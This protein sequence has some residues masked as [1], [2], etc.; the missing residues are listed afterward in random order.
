MGTKPAASIPQKIQ[1]YIND[2]KE[3]IA[4]ISRAKSSMPTGISTQQQATLKKVIAEY[5]RNIKFTTDQNIQQLAQLITPLRQPVF[6]ALGKSRRDKLNEKANTLSPS[7]ANYEKQYG[8][9]I[10]SFPSQ[11]SNWQ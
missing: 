10:K 7:I 3:A 1:D 9:H 11:T 5:E 8:V 6:V 4:Q 2:K